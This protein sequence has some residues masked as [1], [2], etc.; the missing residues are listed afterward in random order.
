MR[1]NRTRRSGRSAAAAMIPALVLAILASLAP[2]RASAASGLLLDGSPRQSLNGRMELFEDPSGKLGIAG[3][4]AAWKAGA[5]T[6]LDGEFTPGFSGSAFWLRFELT[7]ST[8]APATTWLR[9]WP[10]YIEHIEL[11]RPGSGRG[12]VRMGCSDAP[13]G[14][15]MLLPEAAAPL[16]LP[17]GRP[18]ALYLRLES[19]SPIALD[20]SVHT[21]RDLLALSSAYQA[22]LGAYIGAAFLVMLIALLGYRSTAAPYFLLFAAHVGMLILL[23]LPL[24]G[25]TGM[26][27]PGWPVAHTGLLLRILLGGVMLTFM[28]FF[29]T[30]VEGARF[31]W[32]RSHFRAMSAVSAVPILLSPTPFFGTALSL[33]MLSYLSLLPVLAYWSLKV[34][35]PARRVRILFMAAIL[36]SVTG[37]LAFCLH[38]MGLVSGFALIHDITM[39]S[40]TTHLLLLLPALAVRLRLTDTEAKRQSAL[41]TQ[42]AESM[43]ERL[44]LE[45][46]EHSRRLELSIEADRRAAERKEQFLLMMA[47]DYRS[48][49]TV[50]KG[51]LELLERSSADVLLANAEEVRKI[52]RA[53]ERLEKAMEVS[54]AQGRLADPHG[55]GREG[56]I[57]LRELVRHQLDSARVLWPGRVFEESMAPGGELVWGDLSL[58]DTLLF[59]LLDNA[60][61]YAPEGTRISVGCSVADGMGEVRV[62]NAAEEMPEEGLE[63]LFEPFRRGPNAAG[64]AGAGLGLSIARSIALRH[65]GRVEMQKIGVG[66]IE[67]VLLLPVMPEEDE[68]EPETAPAQ[69]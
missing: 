14:T 8:N 7:R 27:V 16:E 9:L 50:I 59:N 45:L 38:M 51:N 1:S 28:L 32:I 39:A 41:A 5:F 44:T 30:F 17:A 40:S 58:L 26:L 54:L 18:V 46:G 42:K 29:L 24:N 4:E 56:C 55:T 57:C 60:V 10:A 34:E 21:Y 37:L 35:M 11:H 12:P 47:H 67:A 2:L 63:A 22:K 13:D 19:Q 15:L 64:T 48:P 68:A 20:A 66:V 43:A 49:L 52:R 33:A 6:P 62:G 69:P 65:G 31:G 25:L 3:A 61:K 53:T 36:S 23:T